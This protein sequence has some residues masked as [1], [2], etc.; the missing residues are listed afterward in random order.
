[1][2]KKINITVVG[3]GYVGMSLSSVLSIKNKVVVL[4]IDKSRVDKINN[5][6]P[7]IDDDDIKDFFRNNQLDLIATLDKKEAYRNAD[8]IFIATP[9]NFDESN[10]S[11]DT[12]SVDTVISNIRSINP[13]ALVVIKSTLPIGHTA[14][15]QEKFKTNNIIFSPEFLQE[16]KAIHGNLYPSRIIVGNE[17]DKSHQV[18]D[19]LVKSS[20]TKDAKKLL[21]TS[22]E[23]ESVKLFANMYLAMRVSFFN[24]LDS[25]SLKYKLNTENIINGISL[26]PRIGDGYNNPSFGYGGYCLPK[27]SKQLLYHFEDIPQNLMSAIVESNSTR[28]DLLADEILLRKPNIVGI[29]RL[30]M[31]SGSENFRS[32]S[33]MGLI[34]RLIDREIEICIY[35]PLHNSEEFNGIKVI[36]SLEDFFEMSDIVIANRFS[37]EL[38]Q[39]KDKVFSR[40]LFCRD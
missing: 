14:K 12:G 9:T 40:D 28:K 34:E 10:G 36:N 15:L 26:D 38:D 7:T 17:S 5:Y 2:S 6:E 25:F 22:T 16:G 35:E 30:I 18:Q 1:M 32:A 13:R 23:A 19:L 3:S 8:F 33:I 31:K 29:Y 39:V 37:N 21:I 4:D 27:D 11:F 20:S 24:E